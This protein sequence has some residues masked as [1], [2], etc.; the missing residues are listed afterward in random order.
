MA[1]GRQTGRRVRVGPV[2]LDRDSREVWHDG[3]P[4]QLSTTEFALLSYL[5]DNAGQVVSKAEI[6]DAIWE[7]D[8]QGNTGVV[9]T[10]VYYLRRKLRDSEQTMIRTVRGAGYL[11]PRTG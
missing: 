11:M 2:E 5:A 8:F 7:Y 9:E 10:Y 1:A 4:V 6:L 3:L